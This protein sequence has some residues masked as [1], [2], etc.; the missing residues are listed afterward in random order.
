MNLEIALAA[1]VS[2]AFGMAFLPTIRWLG[3]LEFLILEWIEDRRH[4]E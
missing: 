1:V 4:L 3:D 2:F